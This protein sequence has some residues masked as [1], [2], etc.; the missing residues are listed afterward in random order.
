MRRGR[1]RC[2]PLINTAQHLPHVVRERPRPA[3][4][5]EYVHADDLQL[6]AEKGWL[7]AMP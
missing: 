5:L 6:I 4:P 3:D 7:I 1:G 2:R